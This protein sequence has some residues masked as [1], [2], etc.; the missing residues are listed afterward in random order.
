MKFGF[1]WILDMWGILYLYLDDRLDEY[2]HTWRKKIKLN[3]G[4]GSEN[5][6]SGWNYTPTWLH[7]N[8]TDWTWTLL[9]LVKLVYQRKGHVTAYT[10]YWSG[11][12]TPFTGLM[13]RSPTTWKPEDLPTDHSEGVCC[14]TESRNQHHL[15]AENSLKTTWIHPAWPPQRLHLVHQGVLQVL[16][17]QGIPNTGGHSDPCL[18]C[19][20]LRLTDPSTDALWDHLKTANL[21]A[22]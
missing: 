6:G 8:L 12:K 9:W 10:L 5:L 22:S 21:Q 17:M 13:V 2:K 14:F 18:V 20:R 16:H 7:I 1:L 11:G 19:C 4:R 15:S 3:E